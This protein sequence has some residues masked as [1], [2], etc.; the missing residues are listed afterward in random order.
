M[1]KGRS[2][3]LAASTENIVAL[4][5]VDDM[6][7]LEFRD[8]AKKN[9]KPEIF[10][11]AKKYRDFRKMLDEMGKSIDAV[12]IST[13]DHT[14]AVAAAKAMKMGKH[15]FVQKPLTH[16]IYEARTLAKIAKENNVVT[17]MGNQGHAGEGD[18]LDAVTAYK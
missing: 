11:K 16:T 1:H 12:T 9:E 6:K 8:H 3:I 15:A 2:D 17:Q 10:E 5:D 7:M 4:V 13:P 18:M 14:H